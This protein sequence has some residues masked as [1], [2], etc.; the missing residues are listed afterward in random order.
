ME[1][2]ESRGIDLESAADR[3]AHAIRSV[4]KTSLLRRDRLDDQA[5]N[6]RLEI[7]SRC[8]SGFATFARGKLHSCGKLLE[9]LRASGQDRP[10]GCILKHK[11][12]DANESCPVG[13]WPDIM[14]ISTDDGFTGE[15]N[16]SAL[17]SASDP[18][19]YCKP[20]AIVPAPETDVEYRES[21]T[22]R[23]RRV[24]NVE[25]R[26]DRIRERHSRIAQNQYL[27]KRET[28]GRG[29][30]VYADYEA[31][32][33]EFPLA[34]AL[35]NAGDAMTVG[36][37]SN[38]ERLTN[39]RALYNFFDKVVVVNL[40]RRPDRMAQFERHIAAIDWPF[41]RPERFAAVEGRGSSPPSWWRAG[42]AAW[43]CHQSH[44]RIIE[45]A[46]REQLSS[47]LILE[48]DVFFENGLRQRAGS[49]LTAVP[50]D[51]QQIYLGGQ[52][53]SQRRQPPV[54]VNDQVLRPFNVNRTHAYALHRRGF[55]LVHQWLTDFE[56]HSHRPAHHVDHRLGALHE[57]GQ[58]KV[59]APNQW[60]AGQ[61][62]SHSNIK[63]KTM[64][65]RLWNGH[66]VKGRS[67]PF[68]AVIGLH[69]SGSSCLAGVLHALGVHMG[70]RLGGYERTGGFEAVGL[71]QI[72]ES[73]FPFPSTDLRIDREVLKNRLAGHINA[74]TK[75]AKNKGVLAGGKYPH[76]CA[77]G[78][79]LKEICGNGL[80]IIHA[81]RPLEE[82]IASLKSRSARSSGWLHISGEQSESVQR[83]LWGR[84]EEMLG[85]IN[86]LSVEYAD[87]IADPCRE[88]DRIVRYLDINPGPERRERAIAHVRPELRKHRL[89]QDSAV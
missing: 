82:S 8:P 62:E 19:E 60:L 20:I 50:D 86:H 9:V 88:I 16:F 61:W 12:R 32:I 57:S 37:E 58:I 63:G 39:I 36:L 41:R 73:A 84:K 42:G 79:L 87:L 59:Y 65:V 77:M 7:C 85:R 72:C 17:A 26:R 22:G 75:V 25:N 55:E 10:C 53:L 43:G 67:Y 31:R 23:T 34:S 48:D 66:Q 56:S 30:I 46:I 5:V 1:T 89:H 69:R 13:H 28:T 6:A 18:P 15:G 64:P 74:M 47:I 54:R 49:F 51:W 27:P 40:D 80:R 71:S 78:D 24:L 21:A 44:V 68:V 38:S 70:N 35:D 33:R 4:V 83:W 52:H 76:L 14:N 81:S 29:Y 3:I 11:A 2:K 45:Q